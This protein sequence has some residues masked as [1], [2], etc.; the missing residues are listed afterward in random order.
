MNFEGFIDFDINF[1]DFSYIYIDL[2]NKSCEFDC[3]SEF[4]THS[5]SR[6]F[7]KRVSFL[8]TFYGNVILAVELKLYILQNFHF[9]T[10]LNVRKI[11]LSRQK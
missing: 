7:I 9:S 3:F 1:Y 10:F 5:K 11:K 4:R 6:N 8:E 2:I